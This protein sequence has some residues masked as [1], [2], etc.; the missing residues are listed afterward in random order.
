MNN[1]SHNRSFSVAKPMKIDAYPLCGTGD[2]EAQRSGKSTGE[3]GGRTETHMSWPRSIIPFNPSEDMEGEREGDGD[4]LP[5]GIPGKNPMRPLILRWIC[6]RIEPG[7][8]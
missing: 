3:P 4:I 6:Q 8:V 1:T 5:G 2:V 7:L